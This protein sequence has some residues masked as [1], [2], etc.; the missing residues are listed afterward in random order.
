MK[1][2]FI[3][4]PV[5]AL[6]LTASLFT[7]NSCVTEDEVSITEPNRYTHND[8]QSY[9]DYFKLFWTIMDE[10]YNY[11]YEQRRNDGLDWDAVYKEYY[12]KFAALKSYKKEGFTPQEIQ[13][14]AQKAVEY[15]TAITA[16]ILDRHFVVR[17]R[18]PNGMKYSFRGERGKVDNVYDFDDKLA[19]IRTKLIPNSI[20]SSN[21]G[22]LKF[23]A[24]NLTSNP[25]VYYLTGNNFA[26]STLTIN[27]ADQYLVRGTANFLTAEEITNNAALKAIK[28]DK[29]R[30]KIRDFALNM[31]D[32]YNT[33][34]N[35]DDVRILN[36]EL[37]VFKS[38]EVTSDAFATAVENL[39][40]NYQNLPK[41]N[42]IT[43]ILRTTPE[44]KDFLEW[45]EER[46]NTH[47]NK[48]YSFDQFSKDITSFKDN[49]KFYQK[50]FNPLH[51]GEIKKLIIDLRDNGGGL[52]L[53]F[54][55]FVE[56]FVTKNTIYAYQRT[57]EGTGRFN[58]TPWVPVEAK[59]HA[60]GIPSNIPIA[61]LTDRKSMSMSEMSTLML[62][63]QGSQIVSIGD[64]TAGGTAGLTTDL[65]SFNGGIN[66][67][68]NDT[69]VGNL[70]EFYVPVMATKDMNAEVI[71]GIGIKPD[72]YVTPPTNEELQTM[73]NLPQTFVDRV[74]AEAIKY[75]SK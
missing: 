72:I 42:N 8:V 68:S 2:N 22:N 67:R 15:L 52:V 55:N 40:K 3:K 26:F 56:R 28:D 30:D 20:I 7:F 19:A 59:K 74:M 73:K 62:K 64:Y 35:S 54:K 53:D 24:G 46:I 33:F 43:F 32:K 13:N 38:T 71:E 31:V 12:P 9:G 60:F 18:L 36:Q 69:S 4:I 63:S 29:E 47:L 57:K 49:T 44:N 65:D 6:G 70:F 45:F 58:Y 27:P 48:G 1:R 10:R 25:D 39:Y 11:F 5:L 51:R 37:K 41:Y 16:P 75:L 61:I 66:N 34:I 14:D 21:T 17:A 23:L 50:L